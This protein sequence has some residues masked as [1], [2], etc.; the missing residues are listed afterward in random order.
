MFRSLS[1]LAFHPFHALLSHS[2]AE[3]Q[4]IHPALY[5]N[6]KSLIDSINQEEKSKSLPAVVMQPLIPNRLWLLRNVLTP[7]LCERI[8]QISEQI[9]Y[10]L[11]EIYC[12]LYHRR[13]NDRFIV[14]ADRKFCGDVRLFEFVQPRCMMNLLMSPGKSIDLM[15]E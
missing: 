3:N 11:A 13:F 12:H 5:P 8:I 2:G 6:L 1:K 10:D 7:R 15:I 14:S 4:T 9:G